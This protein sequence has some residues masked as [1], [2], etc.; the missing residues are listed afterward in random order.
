G[1][2]TL[3]DGRELA[4]DIPGVARDRPLIAARIRQCAGVRR[5]EL[6]IE[7]EPQCLNIEHRLVPRAR[8]KDA[9]DASEVVVE[10]FDSHAPIRRNRK[11]GA[12]ANRRTDTGELDKILIAG[13]AGRF[14]E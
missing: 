13:D 5:A 4:V 11:L 6:V 1:R 14:T 2:I 8:G 3:L 12:E 7:P 10:I 9:G